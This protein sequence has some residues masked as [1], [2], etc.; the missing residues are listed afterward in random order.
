MKNKIADARVYTVTALTKDIRLLIENT[1]PEVW[2]EGEVSNCNKSSA[3]H[4]YFSLKDENSLI[5]CVLFKG[6]QRNIGFTIEN[7]MN[8]LCFGKIGI[9]EKK[10]QYQIVVSALELR[11]KGALEIAFRQL[12]EKLYKEGLFDEGRKRALV[13]LPAHI[14]IVTSPTGAAIRD[15]LKVAHRRFSGID[16]SI[17]PVRV[18]GNEAKY[19]IVNAIKE[20]NEYNSFLLEGKSGKPAIDMIILT[21]GGGSLEDLWPFNEEIVARA[22]CASKVPIVSAVG[23]EIDYTISDFVSDFRA[24]TPS[25]AAELVI[26]L[27]K[28]LVSRVETLHYE[29]YSTVKA[30]LERAVKALSALKDS[31]ILRTPMNLLNQMRQRLDDSLAQAASSINHA[32]ELLYKDLEASRGKLT[33]LSPLAV[34]DRGYSITFKDGKVVKSSRALE[35]GDLLQTTFAKGN[36]SSRVEESE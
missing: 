27:K 16:I 8:I 29:L 15:I 5:G 33:M 30:K 14:A 19:D 22:I 13:Y 1:F 11:G 35:K 34:L 25:A 23:H 31:Y 2:V 6:S 21:R 28:D 26:P 3:G 32:L 36:A 20:L 24:P 10:G 4:I 18:Q 12:K 17:W 7:G 9:Y